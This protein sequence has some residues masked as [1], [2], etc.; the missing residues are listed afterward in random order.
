MDIPAVRYSSALHGEMQ[1][2][3]ARNRTFCLL[4][5]VCACADSTCPAFRRLRFGEEL[6]QISAA[7]IIKSR[8]KR[9]N[10][11]GDM[12]QVRGIEPPCSA[13][14]ADILPL[15][16][17]CGLNQLLHYTINQIALQVKNAGNREGREEEFKIK[18]TCSFNVVIV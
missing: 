8:R 1:Q 3:Q 5:Q 7:A 14:E 13:W 18:F 15:N 9:T 2:K 6:K 16:Y 4:I 17:T 10:A 11:C 12:E